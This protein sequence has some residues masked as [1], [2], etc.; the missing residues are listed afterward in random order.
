M[1]SIQSLVGS[2]IK[3]HRDRLGITQ[4]E[5]AERSGLSQ[6]FVADI[7]RGHKF[8]SPDSIERLSEALAV[9]PYQLF[10]APQDLLEHASGS[11]LRDHLSQLKSDLSSVIDRSLLPFSESDER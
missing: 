3:T 10:L 1:G 4:Q 5:L 11:G 6:S 7:E 9:R 2:N 8:P